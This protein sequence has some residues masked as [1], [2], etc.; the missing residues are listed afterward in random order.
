[1]SRKAVRVRSSALFSRLGIRNTSITRRASCVHFPRNVQPMPNASENDRDESPTTL[2]EPKAAV[3]RTPFPP[4]ASL[5]RRRRLRG[6]SRQIDLV[7]YRLSPPPH[8]R[9]H[10][11]AEPQRRGDAAASSAPP[12]PSQRKGRRA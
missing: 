8:T 1:M 11:P 2:G 3:L 6:A 10:M 12:L 7:E 4:T 5:M 9:Q